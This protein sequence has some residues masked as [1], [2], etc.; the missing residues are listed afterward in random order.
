[1]PSPPYIAV[2]VFAPYGSCVV[3]TDSVAIMDFPEAVSWAMPSRVSP[4]LK[5]TDPVGAP[6]LSPLTA[7]VKRSVAP[8][9]TALESA[10]S[11]VDVAAVRVFHC[12]I[13][14]FASTDPKPVAKS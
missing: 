11:V 12:V 7:A 13:N 4:T 8:K 6:P 14:L 5:L 10:S 3:E 9:M 2:I 1:M